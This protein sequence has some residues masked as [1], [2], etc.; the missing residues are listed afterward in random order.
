MLNRAEQV[1]FCE[2]CTHRK[3]SL[4]GLLCGIT[5]EKATFE[6]SCPD[7]NLDEQE[8]LNLE[9]Q[10]K[11]AAQGD[12]AGVEVEVGILNSGIIGGSLAI[13]GSI[14]WFFGALIYMDRIFF[15]PPILLVIGIISLIRGIQA[16]NE[17]K[18]KNLREKDV[19]DS[20]L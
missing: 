19:L 7:F 14:V 4:Q 15:Y 13:L 6:E 5:G 18:K 12:Y 11:D 2:K 17:K 20:D 3:P 8:N 10:R 16:Q 1:A 9:K